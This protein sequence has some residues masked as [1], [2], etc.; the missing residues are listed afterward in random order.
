MSLNRLIIV[1][2]LFLSI[3]ILPWWILIMLIFFS[4]AFQRTF[5][6]GVFIAPFIDILY[7]VQGLGFYSHIFAIGAL[8][9]FVTLEFFI[10]PRLRWYRDAT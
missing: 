7:A 1:L 3:F 6:E 10:K 8:V 2:L 4:M 5:Y 9:L